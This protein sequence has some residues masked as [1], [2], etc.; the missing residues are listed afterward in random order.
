MSATSTIQLPPISKPLFKVL[1]RETDGNLYSACQN[2]SFPKALKVCYEPNKVIRPNVAGKNTRLFLFEKQ[3]EAN[4][5]RDR[6]SY[7]A[8]HRGFNLEIWRVQGYGDIQLRRAVEIYD[9][10]SPELLKQWLS[11]TDGDRKMDD[12]KIRYQGGYTYAIY[13]GQKYATVRALSLIE[14]I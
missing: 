9:L 1:T 13:E 10:T 2:G 12:M 3:E 11:V 14:R 5:F 6:L 7:T 8:K 4:G